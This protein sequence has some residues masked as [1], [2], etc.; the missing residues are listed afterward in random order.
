MLE[1]YVQMKMFFEYK[2]P[3][4]ILV[5][6]VC[7]MIVTWIIGKIIEVVEERQKK[8]LDKHFPVEEGN[9]SS[10]EYWR[11]HFESEDDK[12]GLSV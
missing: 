6:I 9:E 3:I 4:I 2:L 12:D 10:E 1:K 5:I 11:K 7:I 8:Y